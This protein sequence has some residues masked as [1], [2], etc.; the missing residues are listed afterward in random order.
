MAWRTRSSRPQPGH[1]GRDGGP[2][3]RR[4]FV[5]VEKPRSSRPGPWG[6]ATRGLCAPFFVSTNRQGRW[7]TSPLQWSRNCAELT[8]LGMMECKKALEEAGGDISRPR[9]CCASRAAPR[10]AAASRVAADGAI[11]T[12]MDGKVAALVEVTRDR[13][14]RQ[15]PDFVAFTRAVAELVARQKPPTWPPCPSSAAPDVEARQKLAE[16]RREYH[17]AASS[18]SRRTPAADLRAPG[19]RV[20]VSRLR[21]RRGGEGP[22]HHIA[23]AKPRYMT[24]D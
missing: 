24:R 18:A 2:A 11:G 12:F 16:D 21:G 1:Q 14:R 20:A 23:F 8:G 19:R 5:E 9:S 17:R 22:T 4:L 10:R 3:D 13:L 15:E 6:Q 7:L